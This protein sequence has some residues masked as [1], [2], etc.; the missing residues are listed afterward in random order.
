MRGT[1]KQPAAAAGEG[2]TRRVKGKIRKNVNRRVAK[3]R[4]LIAARGCYSWC[5]YR[6][7]VRRAA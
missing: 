2:T 4:G 7:P 6:S 1:S 5:M 3:W